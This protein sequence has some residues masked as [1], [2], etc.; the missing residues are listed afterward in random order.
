MK[1]AATGMPTFGTAYAAA[2]EELGAL[3]GGVEVDCPY[4]TGRLFH[5][6]AF[7]VLRS[8]TMGSNGSTA[9]LD[10]NV[11]AAPHGTLNQA[12]LDGATHA[13]P[14]TR[15]GSPGS[16]RTSGEGRRGEWRASRR[17][18]APG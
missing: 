1:P 10:A 17:R 11:T 5:G 4:T 2:P 13:I 12:L 3:A 6:P 14:G 16:P 15:P 8:L 7:Q 18:G 9:V